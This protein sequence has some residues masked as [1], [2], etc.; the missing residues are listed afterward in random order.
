M[1]AIREQLAKRV[2]EL[3]EEVS[4]ERERADALDLR[5]KT[6]GV[7]E[8]PEALND[9]GYRL[10]G[11]KEAVSHFREQ[12]DALA[13]LVEEVQRLADSDRVDD[14]FYDEDGELRT[15]NGWKSK[16]GRDLHAVL[17]KAPKTSLAR[18]KAQWQVEAIKSI[19]FSDCVTLQDVM[20]MQWDRAKEIKQ[21][22]YVD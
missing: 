13:A 7:P 2:A 5:L 21:T 12:Y 8:F 16:L 19:D 3:E 17:R 22:Y 20:Q 14:E 9:G 6:L 18:L 15:G 1:D 4:A 11:S 10:L